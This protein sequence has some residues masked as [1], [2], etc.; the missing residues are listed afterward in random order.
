MTEN[1][2]DAAIVIVVA[3][4]LTMLGTRYV[5]SFGAV[6]EQTGGDDAVGS[7]GRPS[8][9]ER[10]LAP[11]RPGAAGDAGQDAPAPSG[12]LD[13]WLSVYA[14][15]AVAA[16]VVVLAIAWA[17]GG[18]PLSFQVRA[19]VM[20]T[21]L[22]PVAILDLRFGVVS[23]RMLVVLVLG[24]G[25]SLVIETF[26]DGVSWS[27]LGQEAAVAAVVGIAFWLVRM[28]SRAGLGGG[29]VILFMLFPLLLGARLAIAAVFVSFAVA[30]VYS[31]WVLATRRATRKD[32]FPLCPAVLVGTVSTV[33]VVSLTG[34]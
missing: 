15:W 33:L 20:M 3:V 1:L 21:V 13:R 30:F 12:A 23:T 25:L 32:S 22:V 7:S 29:D 26:E 28:T 27:S 6:T 2:L 14:P 24:R 18:L 10:R 16:A 34:A 9:A 17:S 11:D 4:L 5:A 31:A 19:A 8:A